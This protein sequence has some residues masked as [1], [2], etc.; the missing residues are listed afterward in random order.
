MP[1]GCGVTLPLITTLLST[2]VHGDADA[3]I[4]TVF[5]PFAAPAPPLE[6]TS[7][8]AAASGATDRR[9]TGQSY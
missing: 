7:S 8:T 2:T 9:R 3:S 4:L 1:A 6:A 5:A